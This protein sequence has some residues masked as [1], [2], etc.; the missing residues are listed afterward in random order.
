MFC[1]SLWIMTN[2]KGPLC[3]GQ[4]IDKQKYFRLERCLYNLKQLILR[5]QSALMVLAGWHQPFIKE[6]QSI[7]QVQTHDLACLPLLP[8]ARC[9][10]ICVQQSKSWEVIYVCLKRGNLKLF[11]FDA[12]DFNEDVNRKLLPLLTQSSSILTNKSLTTCPPLKLKST[13]MTNHSCQHMH[14]F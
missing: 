7:T 4:K 13:D 6:H 2:C 12:I 1:F 10:G 11:I 8:H 3:D 5:S 14:I 9:V